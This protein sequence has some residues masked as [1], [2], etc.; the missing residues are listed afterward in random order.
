MIRSIEEM[1]KETR[2]ARKEHHNKRVDEDSHIVD[3][4]DVREHMR[5]ETRR[6]KDIAEQHR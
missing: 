1:N 2:D 3:S 5:Q 6:M 4:E